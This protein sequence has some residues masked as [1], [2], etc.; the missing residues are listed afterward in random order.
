MPVRPSAATARSSS[1]RSA[2]TPTS[3]TMS[4][5]TGTS[6]TVESSDTA[7]GGTKSSEESS[8]RSVVRA[9]IA[10]MSSASSSPDSRVKT[11]SAEVPSALGSCSCSASTWAASAL[12]GSP[13]GGAVSSSLPEPAAKIATEAA[14]AT[15]R[16]IQEVRAA[17]MNR[18]RV[19][20]S[21][22]VLRGEAGAGRSSRRCRATAQTGGAGRS[23]GSAVQV[24]RCEFT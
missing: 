18:S 23:R 4:R 13:T 1:A 3:E 9:V 17:V 10:A 7:G 16:T 20:M 19:R 14:R 6:A 8:A 5:G 2:C 11:S 15:T 24:S 21:E 22:G 12:S